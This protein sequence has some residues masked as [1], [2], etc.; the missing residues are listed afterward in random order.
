M[1]RGRGRERGGRR[2]SRGCGSS[3]GEVSDIGLEKWK[4]GVP[5]TQKVCN[6]G[7]IKQ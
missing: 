5:K 7:N 6:H 1:R 2:E 4:S 3:I